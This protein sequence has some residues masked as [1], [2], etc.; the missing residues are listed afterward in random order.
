MTAITMMDVRRAGAKVGAIR[1]DHVQDADRMRYELAYMT[2][3]HGPSVLRGHVCFF[4]DG[5]AAVWP[6]N[7][8]GKRLGRPY[9]FTPY[10]LTVGADA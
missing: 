3:V 6:V 1:A 5:S 7:T 10:T 2:G 8:R 4:S 9:F